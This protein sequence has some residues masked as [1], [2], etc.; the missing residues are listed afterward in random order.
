[1]N[2]TMVFGKLSRKANFGR[3]AAIAAFVCVAILTTSAFADGIGWTNWAVGSGSTVINSDASITFTAGVNTAPVWT[4]GQSGNKAF[5]STDDFNGMKVGDLIELSYTLVNPVDPTGLDAP[6]LNIAVTDGVGG[7]SYLLLDGASSP[8]GQTRQ[9]FNAAKYRG[10]EGSGALAP[11]NNVWKSFDDVKNLTIAA[12]FAAN[13]TGASPIGG[14]TGVG[15]DDGIILAWGNR[16]GD[17]MYNHSVTI[18]GVGIQAVPAPTG[19]V[20]LLGLAAMGLVA[21]GKRSWRRKQ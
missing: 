7:F 15:A 14:W 20:G 1:M 2:R 21:C 19:I 9:V 4:T 5:Y 18:S 6:Y 12:G 10:N 3:L 8:G 13:A 16:G 17:P 11:W